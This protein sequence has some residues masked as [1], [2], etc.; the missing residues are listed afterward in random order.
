M[1]L[2]GAGDNLKKQTRYYIGL[3]IQFIFLS[4]GILLGNRHQSEGRYAA[5]SAKE[6][7]TLCRTG[8][9]FFIINHMQQVE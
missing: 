6:E 4:L 1:Y 8:K 2:F 5:Y 3:L 9:N 7:G